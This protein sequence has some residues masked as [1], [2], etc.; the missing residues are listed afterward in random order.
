MKAIRKQ[1]QRFGAETMFK[2]VES[3]DLSKRPFKVV[4]DGDEYFAES[5][6]IATGASAKTVKLGRRIGIYGL[7]SFC[8]RYLRR[9]L[10]QEPAC[11]GGGRR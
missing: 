9:I 8:M 2:S 7:W 6:I 5:L 4:A 11:R 10:F 1:A 3:V